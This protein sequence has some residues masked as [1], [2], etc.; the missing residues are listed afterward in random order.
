MP[1]RAAALAPCALLALLALLALAAPAAAQEGP[2]GVLARADGAAEEYAFTAEDA[3]FSARMLVGESGGQGDVDDAAVLWCM[4]N[5]FTLRPVRKDYP[6]F[7]AFIRAYCTPLQPF[8][9]AQGA[10]D[11]HRKLGTKMVE[12]EPGKWQLERHV[13]LQRRPWEKLPAKARELVLATL[14]GE[15]P[16]PCGNATQFC[17]TATYFRD[18]HGRKPSDDELVAY[19]EDYARSK[20]Y[21]WQKVEGSSL[22]SNVFFVEERFAKLPDGVVVVRAPAGARR[23]S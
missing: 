9:K 15:R 16:S 22:R 1:L 14:R 18:K 13:E 4:L 23:R 20:K 5:S 7:T 19:T 11:R 3:L 10:I 12:V 8:L 6:S 2:F 21:R 17:C